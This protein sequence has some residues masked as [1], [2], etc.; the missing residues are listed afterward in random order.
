MKS[1]DEGFPSTV[2]A[3]W[4]HLPPPDRDQVRNNA[5]CPVAHVRLRGGNCWATD[6]ETAQYTARMPTPFPERFSVLIA[7][8][9][10]G[11]KQPPCWWQSLSTPKFGPLSISCIFYPPPPSNPTC[12]DLGARAGRR[13]R[14]LIVEPQMESC[15][16]LSGMRLSSSCFACACPPL[17]SLSPAR[18]TPLY[19]LVPTKLPHESVLCSISSWTRT[20]REGGGGQKNTHNLLIK[21]LLNSPTL[22]LSNSTHI[23]WGIPNPSFLP[24]LLFNGCAYAVVGASGPSGPSILQFN[25]LLL[26]ASSRLHGIVTATPSRVNGGALRKGTLWLPGGVVPTSL[27]PRMSAGQP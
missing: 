3:G 14:I 13:F 16:P 12:L 20:G 1:A 9:R 17:S 4:H 7:Q 10:G 27:G 23:S 15:V 24:H 21:T 25:S 6:L 5:L 19:R 11:L 22:T 26:P 2:W 8:G 18:P